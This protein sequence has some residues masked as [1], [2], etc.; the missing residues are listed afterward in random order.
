[1]FSILN[2]RGRG[3]VFL[4]AL[5]STR[6]SKF[7]YILKRTMDI[8]YSNS[9]FKLIPEILRQ[10][11]V[12]L[13]RKTIK[14]TKWLTV[15]CCPETSLLNFIERRPAFPF[16]EKVVA[17]WLNAQHKISQKL[18]TPLWTL[19]WD[20]TNSKKTTNFMIRYRG[21]PGPYFNH[22]AFNSILSLNLGE[23]NRHRRSGSSSLTSQLRKK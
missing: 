10:G 19:F 12:N 4:L 1:M 8:N 15:R 16:R 7:Q 17:Q 20:F 2:V 23:N 9:W 18:Q 3:F 22:T 21:L 14:Y 6:H 5:F 11:R 13:C